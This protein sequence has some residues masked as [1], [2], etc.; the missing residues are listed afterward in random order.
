MPRGTPTPRRPVVVVESSAPDI[1][2]IADAVAPRPLLST[3]SAYAAKRLCARHQPDLVIVDLTFAD[4]DG[5]RALALIEAL[6]ARQPYLL[7]GVTSAICTRPEQTQRIVAASTW[8]LAKPL[9]AGRLRRE[10][11]RLEVEIQESGPTDLSLAAAK[12]NHVDKI[13]ELTRGNKSAA[14][15]LLRLDRAALQR[16]LKRR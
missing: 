4:A 16:L 6:R 9:D 3:T 10:L 12:Q 1:E 5:A 2:M 15:R 14:A 13:L 8:F 7:V 11:A